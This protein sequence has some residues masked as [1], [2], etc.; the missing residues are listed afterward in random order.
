MDFIPAGSYRNIANNKYI[1]IVSVK[2]IEET[3]PKTNKTVNIALPQ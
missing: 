2:Y 1:A 3:N